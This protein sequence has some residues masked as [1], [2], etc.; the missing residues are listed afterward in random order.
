MTKSNKSRPSRPG[1]SSNMPVTTTSDSVVG[2]S[3]T[4]QSMTGGM[5]IVGQLIANGIDTVFGLPGVQMY[6]FFDALQQRSDAIRTYGARHEQGTAYMAFGYAR[7]TGRPGICSVVPGPGLLNAT[8]ALATAQGACTPVLCI[9]GQVPS[10]FIGRGRGHLHE[11][12]DQLGMIRSIVKWAARIERPADAPRILNEAFRQML[13]GRPGTVCVEMAWDTMGSQEPVTLLPA[14]QI[15]AAHVPSAASIEAAARLIVDARHPMIM[16]GSGALHAGADVLALAEDLDAPVAAFRGGRGVVAEDHPLG[17]SAATAM[18]LWP[19]T[20]LLIGIGSRLELPYMRWTGMMTLI[21]KPAAPPHLIRIDIDPAEM[22][23]LIPHAAI[24]AD[25]AIGATL[26][27]DAIK[28]LRQ[29][30]KMAKIDKPRRRAHIAEVRQATRKATEKIQPQMAY[31]DVIREVLPR[32][33][34]FVEELCQ[35]GFASQYGY[36]VY[37]PRTYISCGFQGTLGFGFP[38]A[39]GVKAAHPNTPVVSIIG[40][41]GFLFGVQEMATAAQENIALV[42]ILFNNASFGNVLRDQRERYG[43]RIIGAALENPDFQLLAKS[44]NIDSARVRSPEELRPALQRAIAARKPVLIEV[45]IPQGS[46]ISPWEF[47]A[48]R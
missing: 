36:P 46:E 39:L 22:A 19:E 11:L 18:K 48:K 35:A 17:I 43:N 8:A 12:S 31:L 3:A 5:A 10:Q 29:T 33:G 47:I 21:D 26:L 28:T 42:T 37:A 7:S 20:D 16:A 24:L 44:F 9:T 30:K 34:I 41:G 27:R 32:D 1:A 15:T 4:T 13:S 45:E 23:R 14:A 40:D 38:T 2:H 25:A 6:P